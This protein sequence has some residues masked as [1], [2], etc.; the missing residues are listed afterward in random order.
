MR[1]FLIWISLALI[2]ASLSACGSTGYSEPEIGIR[3]VMATDASGCPASQVEQT[4][5]Q[6]PGDVQSLIFSLYNRN[7]QKLVETA[8]VVQSS[9]DDPYTCVVPGSNSF[10]LFNVPTQQNMHLEVK[11][12]GAGNVVTWIGHNYDVDVTEQSDP[13][14]ESV[15]VDIYMRRV[16]KMTA[17]YDC[18]ATGRFFHTSTVLRDKTSILVAGGGALI[19]KD[20]C[21]ATEFGNTVG[22]DL[23]VATN[24]VALF[25]TQTGSF[26]Q[27]IEMDTKRAAHEAVLLA[28]GRV[29]IMG[30]SE[31]LQILHN[32]DGRS[33][34]QSDPML[35]KST[36][37]LY[38]P[39]GQ[40]HVDA[41]INMNVRRI[42]F[43]VTPI[44]RDPPYATRFLVAGGWG[45]GGRLS[46]MQML[47]FNPGEGHRMPTFRM[48]DEQLKGPRAGHTATRVNL[49]GHVFFYG[50][51]E[52]GQAVAEMLE[53]ENEPTVDM[54]DLSDL[55]LPNLYF[56]TAT[57]FSGE[58]KVL[59]TG[60]L[61]KTSGATESLS[62]PTSLAVL[63][64]L[65][66]NSAT[67]PEMGMGT[68]RAFHTG[69]ATPDDGGVLIFGGVSGPSL[70]S[71]VTEV[72]KFDGTS[73]IFAN[74]L[75]PNNNAVNMVVARMGHTISLMRDYSITLI[76]GASPEPAPTN[77]REKAILQSAEVYYPDSVD[78]PVD[79]TGDN[80]EGE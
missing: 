57:S 59:I 20:S 18:M 41:Q 21:N 40:G 53:T 19:R 29:L 47:E 9:C 27:M 24:Q 37:I 78:L 62:D 16:G 15:P 64:N 2:I 38:N 34:L 30:G 44:D 69:I 22:C 75:D 45:E 49:K 23:V 54:T 35:I 14:T 71:G 4:V 1:N 65:N 28:D 51:V 56:H 48:I 79:N 70:E 10:Q 46:N 32:M 80:T 66:D 12:K 36:A 26:K 13:E 6:L 58:K 55:P 25:D 8:V 39:N 31:Q 17:G 74:L 72:E 5:D 7:E 52:P 43:S 33:Y 60:G 42:S 50:G 63:I 67:F 61:Q 77:I 73:G 11:G 76:G 3:F 68:Q